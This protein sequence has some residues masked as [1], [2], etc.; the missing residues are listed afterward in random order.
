MT[1]KI[2]FLGAS[3]CVTGSKYLIEYNNYKILIDC[4]MFQGPR[5]WRTKNWDK[6]S[7]D[8]SKINA[9]LLTHAHIDHSGM[10]PRYVNLGLKCPIYATSATR[11][12]AGILLPDVG[13]IQEQDASFFKRKKASR[14]N[15]PKALYTQKEALETLDLFKTVK[16]EKKITLQ[17]GISATYSRMG[18]ILGAAAI[19]L[20]LGDKKLVFSGDIGR[21]DVPILVDPEPIKTGDYV[22]MESTYGNRTHPE[23]STKED[24]GNAIN[25]TIKKGGIVMIPSFAVGR[26]QLLLYYIRELKQEGIIPDIPVILDSPLASDATD[27]Y[28]EHP[29]NYDCAANKILQKGGHPFEPSKLVFT[30]SQESSKK[31]NDI[32]E[33]M[34]IIAGSGMLSGGRI[35]HHIYR[36][37]TSEKNSL[38]FVG[39]QP[40]G[41][42]GDYLQKKPKTVNIFNQEREVRA[43]IKTLSGLSAHGDK[44]EML[45]WLKDS[46]AIDNQKPKKIFL[47]H[48]E[49]DSREAFSKTIRVETGIECYLPSYEE[50]IEL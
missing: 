49:D 3:G 40:P 36:R 17:K 22:F 10:L 28:F 24:L 46:I 34:I 41:G 35:M 14:H 26:S 19:S 11:S 6:P 18:H 1:I 25:S 23:T 12:L 44:N 43:E 16:F 33:P 5:K 15:P 48:G 42:K 37:I 13:K 32:N 30:R 8:L 20:T 50:S 9:V 47:I 7:I 38:L 31:L 2:S 27:I 21:Y 4:G 39:Y 29:D 45:K